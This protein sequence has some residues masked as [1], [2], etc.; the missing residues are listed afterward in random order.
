L[1]CGLAQAVRSDLASCTHHPARHES[2]K[3]SFS[4]AKETRMNRIA[5]LLVLAFL[6]PSIMGASAHNTLLPRPQKIQY[7]KGNIPLNSLVI[8]MGTHASEEDLF[9]ARE[10]SSYLSTRSGT[11]ILVV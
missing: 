4:T 1:R 11:S 3:E 10:L 9:A 8:R 7:G 5:L 2:K 6:L